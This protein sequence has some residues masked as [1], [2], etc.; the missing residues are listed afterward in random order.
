MANTKETDLKSHSARH[1][2]GRQQRPGTAPTGASVGRSGLEGANETASE[3]Q[4]AWSKYVLWINP[5]AHW[6]YPAIASR[7]PKRH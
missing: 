6:V 1:R 2:L 4:A 5:P 3:P 7:T